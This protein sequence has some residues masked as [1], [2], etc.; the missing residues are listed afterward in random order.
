MIFFRVLFGFMMALGGVRFWAKGWIEE[1]YILPKFHFTYYGFE[2]VKALPGTGMYWLFGALIILALMVAVGLFYRIAIIGFFLTFTYIELI[3]KTTYLNHYY[4]VSLIAFLM[5]WLPANS[6]F[7]FDCKLF[8]GIA[9]HEVSAWTINIIKFQLCVVYFYAGLAKINPDWLLEAMPL[10]IWLPAKSHLPILGP[11]LKYEAAAYFFSWCGALYDLCI[12]FLLLGRKTRPF[13]FLM[14]VI[15]HVT[16]AILFPIG[17]FPYI[18]ILSTL[19]FF[20]SAFHEQV[21]SFFENLL[22]VGRQYGYQTGNRPYRLIGFALGTYC[23]IQ[24]AFPFRYLAYPD[25]LF[26]HEQ[27][28]RFSWRVMLMEKL[29]NVTFSVRDKASNKNFLVN[30]RDFLTPFQEREMSTQPDMILQFAHFLEEEYTSL[31][32]QNPT[33]TA[34]GYV[35]LNGKMSQ[36]FIDNSVNLAAQKESWANKSWILPYP[37]Q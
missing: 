2:W 30:N 29:G 33:V 1:F 9:S 27:G 14:V 11:Y 28:Y 37:N 34:E 20:S 17:M 12:P 8:K 10:K 23:L 19:I 32:I 15:F 4:F 35:T 22:N 31:G 21:I 5:I 25:H 24:L 36:P 7:S 3:D 18:M 6:R 13:A 26:W 16:T